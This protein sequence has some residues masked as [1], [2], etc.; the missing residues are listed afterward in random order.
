M[1]FLKTFLLYKKS[2]SPSSYVPLHLV[3]KLLTTVH[4]RPTNHHTH[5]SRFIPIRANQA[6]VPDMV[7]V[8]DA[9]V[10]EEGGVIVAVPCHEGE[11]EEGEMV[12]EVVVAICE[13]ID[14]H[15]GL[16]RGATSDR[17]SDSGR[18]GRGGYVR[19]GGDFRGG[20]GYYDGG[21][22]G[23]GPCGGCQQ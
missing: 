6:K 7:F 12:I 9:V 19:G 18:G 5:I 11:E 14:A 22:H 10:E 8:E 2:V 17:G 20:G 13:G 15:G 21:D 4:T 1:A 3:L 23:S 16:P